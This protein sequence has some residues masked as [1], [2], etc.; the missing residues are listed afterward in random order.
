MR[1][2]IVLDNE[3]G[4]SYYNIG[5]ESYVQS[6]ASGSTFGNGEDVRALAERLRKEMRVEEAYI[7]V[8][9]A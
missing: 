9:R 2:M 5:M 1:Y 3:D 7:K 6:R 8:I 4:R